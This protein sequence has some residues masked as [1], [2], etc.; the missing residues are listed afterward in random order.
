M[1]I[2]ASVG[3]GGINLMTDVRRIQEALNIARRLEHLTSIKVDRLVGPETI[4]AILDFQ[5]GHT[6][7]ADGRI[8][9]HGPTLRELEKV[10]TAEV[11]STIRAALILIFEGLSRELQARQTKIPQ[12]IQIGIE[13]I[14]SSILTL[15]GGY[16]PPDIQFAVYYPQQQRPTFLLAA[17]VAAA[18]AVA[19]AAAAAAETAILLLLAMIAMLIIIQ[20]APMMSRAIEDLLRKIQILMAEM[21]DEVKDAIKGVEDLVKRNSKAGMRCSAALILFRKLSNQL[22]DLLTE[23]RPTDQLGRKRFEKQIGDLFEKWKKATIDLFECLLS[24]DAT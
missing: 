9:P 22:I 10:I 4:S 14:K 17:A 7:V 21:L 3:K 6:K 8:D 18:P 19:V 20:S 23:P 11:E 16:A 15:K 1:P 24:H 12:S 13:E 2:S 5:R